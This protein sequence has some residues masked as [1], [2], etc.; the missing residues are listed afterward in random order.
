MTT[1]RMGEEG[2]RWFVATVED[3]KDP[4]KLGRVKI[5]V[6]NEHDSPSIKKEDLPWATP[7]LPPT[8]A[9]FNQVGRSPTGLLVGSMVF[10]FYLDGNEKNLPLIWGSYAKKG[11]KGNDVPGLAREVNNLKKS[12]VGPEP[13]S[14]YNAKY[15]YNHVWQTESG[16]VFEVDDTPGKERVHSYHKSGTYVEINHDGQQVTK[17]VGDAYEIV[18]KDKTIFVKGD[19]KIEVKG[20]YSLKVDGK[21][22]VTAKKNI[23]LSS[24]KDISITAKGK[25]NINA[26]KNVEVDSGKKVSINAEAAIDVSAVDA[27]NVIGSTINLN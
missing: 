14:A 22:D 10:G 4:E 5:R 15:P 18:V 20:D 19:C 1:K 21:V 6:V 25:I 26:D 9:G 27:V 2:L 11:D 23:N 12:K 8:S 13:N 16:H 24:D 7:I 3:L 17:V